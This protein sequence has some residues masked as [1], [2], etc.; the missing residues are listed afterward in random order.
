M[1]GNYPRYQLQLPPPPSGYSRTPAPLRQQSHLTPPPVGPPAGRW[2]QTRGPSPGPPTGQ[3]RHGVQSGRKTRTKL[4]SSPPRTAQQCASWSI[5][6]RTV[7]THA[8]C[9]LS[10]QIRPVGSIVVSGADRK[11]DEEWVCSRPT[12]GPRG[13]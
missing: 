5:R 13:G 12:D 6:E 7:G 10:H 9:Y 8:Y 3:D 2:R 11:G 1:A 4:P